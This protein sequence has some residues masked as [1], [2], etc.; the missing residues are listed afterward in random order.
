MNKNLLDQLSRRERQLMDMIYEMGHASARDLQN[1]HQDNLSNSSIRTFLSIMVEKGL[2][3]K[4]K[5]GKKFLYYPAKARQGAA[6]SALNRMVQTFFGG[7]VESAVA[8]LLNLSDQKLS[9][10]E[11]S[12][13]TEMIEQARDTEEKHAWYALSIFWKYRESDS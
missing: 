9:E 4:K 13:I 3:K 10:D 8:G 2:L 6:K 1:Q 7:S 12:R 5:E 11:Y